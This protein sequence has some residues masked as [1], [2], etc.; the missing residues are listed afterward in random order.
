MGVTILDTEGFTNR[1]VGWVSEASPAHHRPGAKV[2]LQL[3]QIRTGI[4]ANGIHHAL[5]FGNQGKI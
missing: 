4:M 2:E 1:G 3:Q 5:T